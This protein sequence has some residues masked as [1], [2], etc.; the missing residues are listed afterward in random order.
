MIILNQQGGF[1]PGDVV[2]AWWPPNRHWYDAEIISTDD[3]CKFQK[4]TN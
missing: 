3:D 4:M 1:K 2:E